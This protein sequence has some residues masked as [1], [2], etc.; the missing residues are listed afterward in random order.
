MLAG[1]VF[2][3]LA[4]MNANTL[5]LMIFAAGLL[6]LQA[7]EAL[8]QLDVSSS[9]KPLDWHDPKWW[10]ARGQKP[11]G[12]RLGQGDFVL[13]GPLV[14]TLR[15]PPWSSRRRDLRQK[16]FSLPFVN[17]FGPKEISARA[18]REDYFAWGERSTPW[19]VLSDRPIPG[20]QSV[21]V[22]VSR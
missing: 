7:Q 13:E 8:G 6:T 12:I 2:V 17:P 3:G 10:E 4:T 11:S 21:L 1:R 18:G 16:F 19:S 5:L 22:S 14:E 15:R 9:T 20:P